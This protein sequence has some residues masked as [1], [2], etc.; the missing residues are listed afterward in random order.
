[1]EF[2]WADSHG[3]LSNDVVLAMNPDELMQLR[4]AAS[5]ALAHGVDQPI[6]RTI[7]EGTD[8]T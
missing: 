8:N 6:F 7:L 3:W 4:F 5:V 2:D 1:M